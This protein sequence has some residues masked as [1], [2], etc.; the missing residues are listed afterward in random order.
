MRLGEYSRT[1]DAEPRSIVTMLEAPN[2]SNGRAIRRAVEACRIQHEGG[3]AA[4]PH[5]SVDPSLEL[6]AQPKYSHRANGRD[7]WN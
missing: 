7:Q 1:T 3:V 4:E 5:A 6:P 2:G